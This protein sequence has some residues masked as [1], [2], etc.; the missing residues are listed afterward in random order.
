MAWRVRQPDACGSTMLYEAG[1]DP[2]TVS[3]RDVPDH[4]MQSRK[5]PD[6]SDM[7]VDL[8]LLRSTARDS[9]ILLTHCD[10]SDLF[11]TVIL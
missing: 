3:H 1:L 10:A 6:P 2:Q 11:C 5:T 8:G 4:T 9:A 7:H